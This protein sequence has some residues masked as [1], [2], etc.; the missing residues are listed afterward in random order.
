MCSAVTDQETKACA[1]DLLYKCKE[2]IKLI[3]QPV[4]SDDDPGPSSTPASK[5]ARN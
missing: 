2:A 1:L 3:V 5:R 4:E